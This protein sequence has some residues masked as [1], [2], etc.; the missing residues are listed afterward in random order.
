MND[1]Q[2]EADDW[3]VRNGYEKPDMTK[4][5]VPYEQLNELF[6]DL[7]DAFY[8]CKIPCDNTLEMTHTFWFGL[9]FPEENFRELAR[10][11]ARCGVSCDCEVLHTI[12]RAMDPE[13]WGWVESKCYS[14]N[15][16][17][18]DTEE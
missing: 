2:P 14:D 1:S 18:D 5:P 13:T 6:V 9:H 15:F 10:Y 4:L 17:R 8:E 12:A 11:F 16:D 7:A 3:F